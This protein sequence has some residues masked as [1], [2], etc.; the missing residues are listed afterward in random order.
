[1]IRWITA[2][3]SL[4]VAL[5]AQAQD[6]TGQSADHIVIILDGSGSME[7]HM[8]NITKM[9]AAKRA[10]KSV[11]SN[12]PPDTRVGLIV[13][14]KTTGT[15][16]YPLGPIDQDKLFHAVDS[17][18]SGGATPLGQNL[19]AGAD[20][21]LKEREAQHGYGTYRLLVVTDGEAGDP[22]L[23][24]AY[25]P[26]ILN[27]GIT[28]DVIGV[29]MQ[30][31][32]MLKGQAHTYRSADDPKSLEKAVSEVFAEVK[33]GGDDAVGADAFEVLEGMPDA[34]A[35]AAIEALATSS[36]SNHPI[37]ERPP[38]PKGSEPA[39]APAAPKGQASSTDSAACAVMGAV[40]VP[41]A[42]LFAV[43]ALTRRRR[44]E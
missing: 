28:L 33:V 23:V 38:A 14:G 21:L 27:R 42:A 11:L 5:S 30:Q 44:G 4:W 15:W 17:V 8:G 40:P 7:G 19:K 43:L 10:L 22:Q 9:I 35:L 2:L 31:D 18:A 6:A 32:H 1:M 16:V 34:F 12:S 36:A 37:G 3:M 26:D 39:P 41:A 25:T 20:A 24:K 29:G 13:F